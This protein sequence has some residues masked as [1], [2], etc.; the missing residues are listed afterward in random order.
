[1]FLIYL[2]YYQDKNCR[3]LI[4]IQNQKYII[5]IQNGISKNVLIKKQIIEHINL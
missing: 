1:M 2:I 5:D 3:Y 4:N